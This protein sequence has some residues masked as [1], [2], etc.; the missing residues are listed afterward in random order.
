M[1]EKDVFSVA[2]AAQEIGCSVSE[3]IDMM[4]SDGL[5][6]KDENDEIMPGIHPDLVRLGDPSPF[7]RYGRAV[8]T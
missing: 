6:M 3:L 1:S 4:V 8:R 2:D 7:D 5:L